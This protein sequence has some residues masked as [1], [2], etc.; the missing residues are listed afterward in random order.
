MQPPKVAVV[1]LNWNGKKFLKQFLPSVVASDYPN[2]DIY[3][4]DNASTDN[5][6]EFIRQNFPEIKIIL[7][8]GNLGFAGGYNEALSKIEADY[9]VLL[10]QD[11]EVT[12]N[13]IQPVIEEMEKDHQIAACQPKLRA[14]HHKD[15]F[16]YAG[17]AGG[18]IDRYGYPFCRGRVFKTVEKDKGQYDYEQT[19][20]WASGAA[21]FIRAHLYQEAGGLDEDFFAHMEEIDLCWRLQRMGYKIAVCPRAMVYHVGGGSLPQGNPRK[22]YLNFRNN[23]IMLYKNLS[24]KERN[25]ILFSRKVL[26]GVAA[27]KSLLSGNVEE[28]KSIWKAHRSY[29]KWKSINKNNLKDI[30][31]LPFL[32]I[33][34]VYKGSIIWDYFIRKI[35]IFPRSLKTKK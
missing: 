9:F 31:Y 14:F 21:L 35:K 19:A 25:T 22:V 6:V 33:P 12:S 8:S 26:D 34:G 4:A 20:F 10:N 16:E 18:W 27:V 1:I 29:Y 2:T 28:V 11:V 3:I 5:S 13:W 15:F 24:P 23:L 17:A 7:N 32:E 30:P